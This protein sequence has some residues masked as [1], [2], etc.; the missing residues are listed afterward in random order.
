M[1]FIEVRRRS[2]PKLDT[3]ARLMKIG[4]RRFFVMILAIG[5]PH[6]KLLRTFLIVVFSTQQIIIQF[7]M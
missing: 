7:A 2:L 6:Q 5:M 1:P 3:P 4:K